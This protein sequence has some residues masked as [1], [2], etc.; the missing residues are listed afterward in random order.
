MSRLLAIGLSPLQVDI[1][2]RVAKGDIYR[3]IA[4]DLGVSESSIKYHMDR[5]Y[6]LLNLSGR[7]EAVAYAVEIGLAQR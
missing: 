7:A 5:V 3:R 2:R 6:T 4:L 1:L